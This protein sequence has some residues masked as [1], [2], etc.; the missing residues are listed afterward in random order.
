MFSILMWIVYGFI[1]GT[2]AK[3]VFQYAFPT[4][5]LNDITGLYTILLGAGGSYVGGL[6]NFLLGNTSSVISAT[7]FSMGIIG[8]VIALVSLHYIQSKGY[9]DQWIN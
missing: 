7:G 6:I 4:S 3:I 1:V 2:V 8:A 5:R 9:L